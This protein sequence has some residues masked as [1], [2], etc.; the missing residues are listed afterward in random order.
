MFA[1]PFKTILQEDCKF[2]L[3]AMHIT[4]ARNHSSLLKR[5]TLNF[6]RE[7]SLHSWRVYPVNSLFLTSYGVLHALQLI[8]TQ[9][10]KVHVYSKTA[11]LCFGIILLILV[12]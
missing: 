5:Q 3:T 12:D 9:T 10:V 6:V 8:H 4:A 1:R 2:G 7:W 11:N